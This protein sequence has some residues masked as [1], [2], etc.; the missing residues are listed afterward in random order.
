VALR[1]AS[2]WGELS[3]DA[4]AAALGL[5]DRLIAMLWRLAH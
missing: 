3:D 4:I 5:L 2:A 1:V